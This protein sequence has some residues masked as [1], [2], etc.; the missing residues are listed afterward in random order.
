MTQI[1][2]PT[3][4]EPAAAPD[5]AMPVDDQF[6]SL[7][8]GLRTTLPGV[9]LIAAFLLTVPFYDHWDDLVHAERLAYYIAFGSALVSSLLLMAPSSHQRLRAD[10]TGGVA[11]R[12]SRHL[13]VAVRLT[14]VGTALFAVAITAVAYLVASFVLGVVAAV[15]SAV[16][17]GAVAAWSWF[18]V[19]LVDF[20]RDR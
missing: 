19:P 2:E 15:V 9:Q 8:E 5:H 1:D 17:I 7:L 18:Y 14:I 3:A 10:S 20:E 12:S 13:A 6:R 11:R 4:P 16:V